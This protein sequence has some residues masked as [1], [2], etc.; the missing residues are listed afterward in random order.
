MRVISDRS[1]ILFN[2][3]STSGIPLAQPAYNYVRWTL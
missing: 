1:F 2:Q 3:V